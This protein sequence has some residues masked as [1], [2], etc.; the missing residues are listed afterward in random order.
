MPNV[1]TFVAAHQMLVPSDRSGDSR[2]A[3]ILHHSLHIIRR[4]WRTS[5]G[6]RVDDGNIPGTFVGRQ[7]R[8][9]IFT[10]QRRTDIQTYTCKFLS[11]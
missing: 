10:R 1:G 5:I 4:V 11:Q 2:T 9:S 7:H 6:N 3:V 8:S